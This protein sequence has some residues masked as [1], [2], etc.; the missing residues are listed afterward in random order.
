M[1]TFESSKQRPTRAAALL[2]RIL[3]SRLYDRTELATELAVTPATIDSYLSGKMDMPLERQLCL[4][5]FVIEKIPPLTRSGHM[6]HGQVRA[7][8]AFHQHSTAVHQTAP[9]PGPWSL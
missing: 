7:A 6:L 1:T 4:A 5:L 3:A 8:I 9:P 2:A